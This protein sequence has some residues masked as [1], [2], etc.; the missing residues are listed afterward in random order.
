[1][2]IKTIV[3][4]GQITVGLFVCKNEHRIIL[5][6]VPIIDD[7]GDTTGYETYTC[8]QCGQD[9]YI[10]DKKFEEFGYEE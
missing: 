4:T 8:T 7:N 2:N 3:S 5:Q 9:M 1:M 6:A 10:K